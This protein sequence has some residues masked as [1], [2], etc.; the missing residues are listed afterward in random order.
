MPISEISY[1]SITGWVICSS[2][3]DLPK[4][5]VRLRSAWA[6]EKHFL[7]QFPSDSFVL[8]SLENNCYYVYAWKTSKH[9]YYVSPV[10]TVLFHLHLSFPIDS[11]RLTFLKGLFFHWPSL[12]PT[13]RTKCITLSQ[14]YNFYTNLSVLLSQTWKDVSH[15]D[16]QIN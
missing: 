4:V 1:D 12:R 2:G 6:T 16:R 9:I 14:L 10:Y 11:I 13:E 3:H 8:A 15:L 7:E 5:G